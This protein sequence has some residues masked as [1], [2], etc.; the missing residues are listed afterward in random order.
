MLVQERFYL[1]DTV[2]Y[3]S[4]RVETI[5]IFIS[6]FIAP[7]PESQQRWHL[8]SSGGGGVQG[9]EKPEGGGGG[10]CLFWEAADTKSTSG[11]RETDSRGLP[12]RGNGEK[13]NYLSRERKPE[14]QW[15]VRT[16][17]FI[18]QAPH[19]TTLKATTALDIYNTDFSILV[20]PP[21]K[22]IGNILRMIAD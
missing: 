8:Q 21:K 14:A 4:T 11:L 7:N 22:R 6:G 2:I 9:K 13:R 20:V 5:D 15:V 1:K 19:R 3:L 16:T 10:G 18:P 12:Q 17:Q